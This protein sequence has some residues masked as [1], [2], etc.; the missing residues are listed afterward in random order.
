MMQH[1]RVC[2]RASDAAT[3]ERLFAR[4]Q[5]SLDVESVAISLLGATLRR[6]DV[7]GTV[8]VRVTEV[9][10]YGGIGEDAASHAHRG[11]TPRNRVMFESAGLLYVY[12]VYGMHWCVNVVSGPVGVGA[13][14]LV[15]AGE[16][17][18]GEQL[19]WSRRPTA[20]SLADLARGPGN[21]SSALGVTAADSGSDLVSDTSA[22]QLWQPPKATPREVIANGP[23]VGIRRETDR[24]WR[25]WLSRSA[26]V[27]RARKRIP[28]TPR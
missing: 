18:E 12:F 27:S 1:G 22:I 8:A 3:S 14:V 2:P 20:R 13:A 7:S 9:E 24:P 5:L 23:R 21:L 4:D 17:I 19:A 26:S 25:W 15:R 6:S 16:V 10:A 11:V 28:H